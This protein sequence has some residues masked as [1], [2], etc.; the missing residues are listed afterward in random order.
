M[1]AAVLGLIATVHT[2]AVAPGTVQVIHDTP[3]FWGHSGVRPEPIIEGRKFLFTTS[4]GIEVMVAP[5]SKPVRFNDFNSKDNVLLD[6]ET[7]IQ[8]IINDPAEFVKLGPQWFENNILRQYT[9]IVRD[10]VKR[11]TM[12]QMMS[13][14]ETAAQVDAVV[15]EEIVKLVSDN[16]LPIVILGISLGHAKPNEEVVSQINETAKQQQREKTLTAA[17]NAE[18]KRKQEQNARADADKEYMT[19]L[20][21]TTEQYLRSEEIRAYAAACAGGSNCVVN[22]GGN[23]VSVRA[24]R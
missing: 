2:V 22:V 11:Y 15:T 23:P 18:V 4:R 5:Q 1:I 8:F 20:G 21:L 13:N 12:E 7:S 17:Y 9:A 19:Q 24:G 14:V 10:R 3:Y 6:F 16:K